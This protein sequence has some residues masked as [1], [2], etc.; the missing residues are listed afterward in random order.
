MS[1]ET[2]YLRKRC[3][4]DNWLAWAALRHFLPTRMVRDLAFV[5][6][7]EMSD[8]TLT[9]GELFDEVVTVGPECLDSWLL[10]PRSARSPLAQ[11]LQRCVRTFAWQNDA[12]VPLVPGIGAPPGVIG[13]SALEK[14]IQLGTADFGWPERALLEI[15][16]EDQPSISILSKVIVI[17]RANFKSSSTEGFLRAIVPPIVSI[18][19]PLAVAIVKHVGD[20]CADADSWDKA[21]ALYDEAET[22]V[23]QAVDPAWHEFTSSLRAMITQSR[24][25]AIRTLNGADQAAAF[26][27]GA[28]EGAT[29]TSAPLLLANATHD[30]LAAS[31]ASPDKF[32][33]RPDQRAAV[34]SP[35]LLSGTH[36]PSGALMSWLEG[37]F[38][39]S[40]RQFWAVLRRQ[41]ALGL[42]TESRITKALYTRSILDEIQATIARQRQPESFQMAVQL[43]IES[44]NNESVAKVGWNEQLI[45]AY[46]DQS[47]VDFV[48]A[49]AKEHQGSKVG[50]QGVAVELFQQWTELITTDRIKI[51]ESMLKYVAA[52]AFESSGSFY[53]SQNL[54]G[55]SLEVLRHAAERRPELRNGVASEVAAAVMKRLQVP[56]FWTAQRA[57][58]ETASAY[59]DAF[60]QDQ[61]RDI[62]DIILDI[63]AHTAPA[64]NIEPVVRPALIFLVS[65]P[66]KHLAGR[67]PDLGRRIVDTI[68]RFGVQQESE[69]ARV[70]FYLHDFDPALLRDASVADK[71]R[72]PVIQVRH[73]SLQSNASNAVENIEALLLAPAISGS[74]GV[75]DAL[76]G[77]ARILKLAV[78]PGLSI[79]LPFAYGPL[80]LLANEQQKI[81]AEILV[82]VESF[83]DSLHPILRLIIELWIQAKDRPLLFAAF[84]L[85]QPTT[86]DPVIIHNW[87]YALMLFADSLQQSEQLFAVL[88]AAKTQPGLAKAI[89]GGLTDGDRVV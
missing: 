3:F 39:D 69:H 71:L 31:L 19:P 68:L 66:V 1:D 34:L 30:A 83:R 84:S 28:V 32:A 29:M 81:A 53:S 70:L 33:P 35:P 10:Q 17:A 54:G 59:Q 9:V 16:I 20:L 79:A 4:G 23:F 85:P 36:R 7:H 82:S 77:L 48:V 14:A 56:G 61:L 49:H 25:S 86:P 15:H 21:L 51:A 87:A 37:Q 52:L 18:D 5:I 62:L 88:A 65:E 6:V 78:E 26:L 13:P 11:Y 24:A 60:S 89:M 55:R 8:G 42:A 74:D 46:V 67:V 57:A 40:R 41:I 44:E 22:R 80:L 27:F 47:L 50:R 43:L 45:N 58:L 76:D 38:A 72:D 2:A 75:H 63:L 73:R 12:P 64:T